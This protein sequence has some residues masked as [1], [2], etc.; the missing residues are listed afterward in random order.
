LHIS[1]RLFT[2]LMHFL[3]FLSLWG[4]NPK[5][6]KVTLG[7]QTFLLSSQENRKNRKEILSQISFK[8][9]ES[10]E[11]ILPLP[12]STFRELFDFLN[13]K[14]IECDYTL[15][16]TESFLAA[17]GIDNIAKVI[18]WLEDHGGH[19]DCEVLANVEEQFGRN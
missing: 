3:R 15:K 11:K 17:N 2:F 19:C 14:L 4:S 12:L 6:R 5:K 1:A 10:F 7:K 9:K 8:Q 18:D 13:K 16:L